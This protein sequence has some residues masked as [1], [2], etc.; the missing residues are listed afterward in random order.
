M[1]APSSSSTRPFPSAGGTPGQGL[2]LAACVQQEEADSAAATPVIQERKG[3]LPA[4]VFLLSFLQLFFVGLI[5]R[6]STAPTPASVPRSSCRAPALGWGKEG[7]KMAAVSARDHDA[8]CPSSATL[9]WHCVE[10]GT[11]K[12]LLAV[13]EG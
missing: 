5:L 2:S 13:R 7:S 6:P 8:H 4:S 11:E 3:P 12:G 9:R 1:H 10:R